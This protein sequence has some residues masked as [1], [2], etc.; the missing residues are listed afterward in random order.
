VQPTVGR[1]IEVPHEVMTAIRLHKGA[2]DAGGLEDYLK[3]V[4]FRGNHQEIQDVLQACTLEDLD[5]FLE[6]VQ[7]VADDTALFIDLLAVLSDFGNAEDTSPEKRAKIR[8][9]VDRNVTL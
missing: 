5:V 3:R 6:Y 2:E 8:P 9:F 1:A 7:S 4:A